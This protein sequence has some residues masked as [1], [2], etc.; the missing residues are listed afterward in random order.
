MS[1][2]YDPGYPVNDLLLASSHPVTTPVYSPPYDVRGRQQ[3]FIETAQ[4]RKERIEFLKKREW[5]RRVAEWIRATS[6]RQDVM[7]FG[8]SGSLAATS[9][10]QDNSHG[11][12]LTSSAS[13]ISLSSS[14]EEEE[15]YVIYSSSPSSSMSS[16]SDDSSISPVSPSHPSNNIHPL[17]STIPFPSKRSHR[18][19]RSSTSLMTPRRRP[20]L[21]SIY[22]VPEED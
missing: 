3:H 13:S 21:S 4:Q 15:P 22:E 9:S 16:L 20:S 6:A 19:R 11:A 12:R 17:S 8:C 10:M 7:S 5:A 1:S 18:R 14:E 2:F